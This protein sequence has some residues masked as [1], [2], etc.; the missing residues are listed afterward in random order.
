MRAVTGGWPDLTSTGSRRARAAPNSRD[1][2]SA[3]RENKADLPAANVRY[4]RKSAATG[5]PALARL[6]GQP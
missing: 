2:G 1:A 3:V 5:I 6:P 4:R